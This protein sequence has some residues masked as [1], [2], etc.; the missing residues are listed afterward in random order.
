MPPL[1]EG[2]AIVAVALPLEVRLRASA[3][4]GDT[5]TQC[6]LDERGGVLRRRGKLRR[7]GE[8]Q[9]FFVDLAKRDS[10]RYWV[11]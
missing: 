8:H 2:C 1:P 4:S 5:I 9:T 10:T 7:Y 6:C 3:R 11:Q